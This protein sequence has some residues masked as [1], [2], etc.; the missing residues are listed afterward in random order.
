MNRYF[1]SKRPNDPRYITYWLNKGLSEEEAI[2]KVKYERRKHSVRCKEHW[3]EKGYSEEEAI[4]KV[5]EIQDNGESL[6]GRLVPLETREKTRKATKYVNTIDYWIEKYGPEDGPVKFEEYK[7]K[8]RD[9]CRKGIEDRKKRGHNFRESSV[10]CIEYWLKRG[11]NK[12]EAEEMV[13]RSQRRDLDFFVKKYGK[14]EG[15][16]KWAAKIKRWQ[17]SFAQN[18]DINVINEKRR[19][20]AHV[21]HYTEDTVKNLDKLNFY[22]IIVRDLDDTLFIKYGLTKH[23]IWNR[24]RPTFD[25]ETVHFI[26]SND[27]VKMVK[28]ESKLNELYRGSYNP[29]V[30]KTLECT[31]YTEETLSKIEEIIE[32]FTQ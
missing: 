4:L 28:L 18:N 26:T 25:Y 24:W 14:Q 12:S 1:N 27:P 11:Y 5:K 8:Q 3:I 19:I 2:E 29:K 23:Q 17:K 20:N 7:N 21:G 10:R 15:R 6:K 22:V 16:K 13:S 31:L 32:G 9:N 30:I